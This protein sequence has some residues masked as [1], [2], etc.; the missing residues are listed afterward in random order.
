M[1]EGGNA[2]DALAAAAIAA[3]MVEPQMVDLG[4]YVSCA[5]V[6]EGSTG[7]VWTVDA[8]S[9]APAAARADMFQVQPMAGGPRGINE[10]EYHCSVKDN[11]NVYGPLSVSVPGTL[12]GIGAL[13]ERWG[14]AKWPA[15]LAPAR[16]LLER[17]FEY[18]GVADAIQAREA[19][20]RKCEPAVRHLMPEGRVPRRQDTW[21]RPD[22]EKTL[23]HLAGSGWRDVYA[24]E[25]GLRVADFVGGAGGILSRADL[26]GF[27]PRVTAGAL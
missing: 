12:G 9:V 14:R 25:L 24:G 27:Q 3:C 11:A 1:Q 17:G 10:N 26:A 4:G 7:R 13:W 6:L 23:A 2:F 18:G 16:E 15:I 19:A 5:V 8:N 22:M 21:R 20:L